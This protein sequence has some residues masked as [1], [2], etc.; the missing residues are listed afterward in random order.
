MV[1]ASSL[2]SFDLSFKSPL[3]LPVK[4][5]L[6]PVWKQLSKNTPCDQDS[7]R[8][9][10]SFGLTP[11]TCSV[12][13]IKQPLLQD[14]AQ[15]VEAKALNQPTGK[16]IVVWALWT[17]IA[18]ALWVSLR[19]IRVTL[20]S[21]NLILLTSLNLWRLGFLIHLSSVPKD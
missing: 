9:H 17:L 18:S 10:Q 5:L 21:V 3:V 15:V 1:W 12:V 11:E 7:L 14:V 2:W 19:P 20:Q 6:T 4:H 16:T 13:C 8:Q